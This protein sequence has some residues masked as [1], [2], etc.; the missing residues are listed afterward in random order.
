MYFAILLFA[1][2]IYTNHRKYA[3]IKP[4][5]HHTLGFI[6]YSRVNRKHIL[7]TRSVGGIVFGRSGQDLSHRVSGELAIYL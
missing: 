5:F 6:E 2:N 4:F 1:V 7:Q 3:V